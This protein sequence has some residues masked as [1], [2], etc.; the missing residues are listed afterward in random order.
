VS[1]K[2][3]SVAT[4]GD[5]S[6]TVA[7]ALRALVLAL[8]LSA[9]ASGKPYAGG[10]PQPSNEQFQASV[11]PMLLR[12]C[13]FTNC[14][15]DAHRFFQV[16]GPGRSRLD[17]KQMPSDPATP[18]EIALSYDRARAKLVTGTTLADSLLLR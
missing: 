14:H 13:A 9:C 8:C 18:A 4:V 12:N 6:M 16:F 15:G 17:P 10:L 2:L 11:Y 7:S 5:F 1:K 3:R